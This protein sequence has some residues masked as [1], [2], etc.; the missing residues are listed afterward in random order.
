M[1][2][3]VTAYSPWILDAYR[4]E[5]IL[6]YPWVEGYKYNASNAQPWQ[7]YDVDMKTPHRPVVR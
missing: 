7:Y 1:S 4:I 6:V 3:L 2:E 5:N